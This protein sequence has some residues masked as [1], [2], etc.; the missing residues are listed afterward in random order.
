MDFFQTVD[1]DLQTH[2][3]LFTAAQLLLAMGAALMVGLALLHMPR[4]V[5]LLS[6]KRSPP[7]RSANT[8]KSPKSTTT[9]PPVTSPAVATGKAAAAAMKTSTV[10]AAEAAT[11]PAKR[12]E[13]GGAHA[14]EERGNA[15]THRAG[16]GGRGL[17]DDVLDDFFEKDR[18]LDEALLDTT[19]RTETQSLKAT[20][21]D[22]PSRTEQK[23]PAAGT[24]NKTDSAGSGDGIDRDL[25][26]KMGKGLVPSSQ[27]K[28]KPA[29]PHVM[30]S[31]PRSSKP[32]TIVAEKD[33]D[34]LLDDF[35]A[36]ENLLDEAVLDSVV[37]AAKGDV[38]KRKA[39]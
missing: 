38:D 39:N 37:A 19:A 33:L 23:A 26:R 1:N 17:L 25:A 29:A 4:L 13:D 5:V 30:S 7:V 31:E 36:E 24:T 27:S 12:P 16:T 10:P 11:P 32:P 35:M 21:T 28:K 14:E 22:L 3:P 6:A 18:I 9:E 34:E 2:S 8:T 20:S 15:G